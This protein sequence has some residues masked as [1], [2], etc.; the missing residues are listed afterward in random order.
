MATAFLALKDNYRIESFLAKTSK[1]K[2]KSQEKN[3]EDEEFVEKKNAIYRSEII[4]KIID[5]QKKVVFRNNKGVKK[6][7]LSENDL[8][9]KNICL[10]DADTG[11]ILYSVKENE[12]VFPASLTKM[13][14]TIV[15]VE[16]TD[17]YQIKYTISPELYNEMIIEDASMAGFKPGEIVN[18]RDLI[19]GT[20][21]PSGG[22]AA[23]GLAEI[24][25]GSEKAHVDK[26]NEKVKELG[27]RRTHFMNA[28]GLHDEKNYSTAYEMAE[29][30][31]YGLKNEVFKEVIISNGYT[32]SKTV[33]HPDGISWRYSLLAYMDQIDSEGFKVLGGKTGYT[34]QAGLC[35]ASTAVVN[36]K[37]YILV[38][39]GALPLDANSKFHFMDAETI[40]RRIAESEI[41]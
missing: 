4:Q 20:M 5:A 21:L 36:G 18:T 11:E 22:E 19:Y 30:L 3:E 15:A 29:I 2:I 31:R 35:L 1:V 28:S 38:T 7:V 33:E 39:L 23:V 12:V 14:T 37:Q 9:S 8:Y 41:N 34:E 6:L 32:S 13:M 10:M 24:C 16:S 40:Y 17:D 26:M 25:S 27:L